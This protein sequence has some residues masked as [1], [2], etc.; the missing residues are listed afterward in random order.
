MTARQMSVVG[1]ALIAASAPA[2][3]HGAEYIVR[4]LVVIAALCG[5]VSGISSALLRRSEGF[6][7]GIAFGVLLTI[8][9]LFLVYAS[10]NESLSL[11]D[12]FGGLLM[13]FIFVGFAGAI[14]LAI[15]FLASYRLTAYVRK[16]AQ[17]GARSDSTTP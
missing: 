3:A 9:L 5:G 4:P 6:G 8:A 17:G 15:V 1:L 14:P 16:R 12:F 2:H 11:A 7:L 10:A 13:T